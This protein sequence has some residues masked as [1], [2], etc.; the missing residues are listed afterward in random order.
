M[1]SQDEEQELINEAGAANAE[2]PV[3]RVFDAAPPDFDEGVVPQPKPAPV[4][5]DVSQLY[6]VSP[7]YPLPAYQ[8]CFLVSTKVFGDF[9][10]EGYVL[11]PGA[12]KGEEA[13]KAMLRVKAENLV[14]VGTPVW[15]LPE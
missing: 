14:W 13:Y 2:K 8:G 11:V 9:G 12:T 3:N 10:V 4:R 1:S 6:Q 5:L 15:V 7:D